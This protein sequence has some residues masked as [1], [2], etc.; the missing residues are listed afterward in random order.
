MTI[1]AEIEA[2]I[3]RYHHVEKWPP[4]T[5]ARQLGLHHCT[6][7]RVLAQAGLPHRG[8]GQ[9]SMIEPYLPFIVR[10]LEKFPTLTDEGATVL[11]VFL[12]SRDTSDEA[13]R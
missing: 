11:T 7:Q 6:V 4:G 1:A 12:E 9:A 5:I 10:T 8:A 3:L 13:L 2:Q